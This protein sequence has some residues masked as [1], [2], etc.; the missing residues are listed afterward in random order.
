[1]SYLYSIC[2]VKYLTCISGWAGSS[3]RFGVARDILDHPFVARRRPNEMKASRSFCRRDFWDDS[4][5]LWQSSM[6]GVLGGFLQWRVKNLTELS[7]GFELWY[8][9]MGKM[10]WIGCHWV[11]GC[12]RFDE[13][14]STESWDY[15]RNGFY[16]FSQVFC[17]ASVVFAFPQ[18]N[19]DGGLD[20]RVFSAKSW[21]VTS[22]LRKEQEEEARLAEK[23]QEQK[24]QP[25]T[26]R[27]WIGWCR[28]TPE[29]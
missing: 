6:S 12:Q 26:Q 22:M 27:F 10:I 16:V 1:M 3:M 4:M 14:K 28:Y 19:F 7:G 25:K 29:D 11:P 21:Q 20:V 2:I 17:P 23:L 8:L 18:W 15:F 13:M 9:G 5:N 24:Y